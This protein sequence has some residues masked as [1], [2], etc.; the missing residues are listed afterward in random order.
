[1]ALQQICTLPRD[2]RK[3]ES[4]KRMLILYLYKNK[5]WFV[6]VIYLIK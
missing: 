3:R 2:A 4:F 6:K 5:I 1:M